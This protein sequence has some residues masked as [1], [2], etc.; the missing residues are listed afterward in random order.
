MSKKVI[1]KFLHELIS[2]LETLSDADL[3]KLETGEYSI[4]L[5]IIKAGS[6]LTMRY[7]EKHV[8]YADVIEKLSTCDSREL[9]HKILNDY[10]SSKRDLELF[11]K[12]IKVYVMKQDKVDKVREKIIEGTV[13]AALRSSAIQKNET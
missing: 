7:E 2:Q 13:G 4:G 6:T 12:H 8:N 1:S 9:G 10:F 3:K 5:K 11:A